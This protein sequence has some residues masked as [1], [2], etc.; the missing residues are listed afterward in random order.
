[1][2]LNQFGEPITIKYRDTHGKMFLDKLFAFH[3]EVTTHRE[4]AHVLDK[5]Q[6]PKY[7]TQYVITATTNKEAPRKPICLFCFSCCKPCANGE[8]AQKNILKYIE[9]AIAQKKRFLDL[10]NFRCWDSIYE[11]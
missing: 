1:M 5:D 11:D 3:A 2:M 4:D 8:D 7:V 9:E 6:K 10:S